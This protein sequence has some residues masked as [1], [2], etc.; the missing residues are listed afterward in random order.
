MV[1]SNVRRLTWL[2]LVAG[3]INLSWGA[4]WAPMIAERM[5]GLPVV[6]PLFVA[7]WV[8]FFASLPFVAASLLFRRARWAWELAVVSWALLAPAC[9]PVG[10]YALYLLLQPG[11]R[12]ALAGAAPRSGDAS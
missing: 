5:E 4:A 12:E 6:F 3:V 2:S 9:L 10:A 8:V 1:E 11:V 7:A